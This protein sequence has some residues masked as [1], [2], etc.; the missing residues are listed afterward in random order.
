MN[1]KDELRK[2]VEV[3]EVDSH[4]YQLRLK[5][6]EELP[7]QLAQLTAAFEEKK[8]NLVLYEEKVKQAQLRKKERELDLATKEENVK[9]TQGQLYSLKTN[10]EY[11]AKL[12]EIASLKADVSL[13]EEEVLKVMATI[14]EADKI[15]KAE[16]EK[17]VA[18]E[19]K[20]K[21]EEAKVKAEME[22]FATQLA[23]LDAKRSTLL[24]GVDK[25]ILTR[26][27]RLV[28]TRHG[29]AI[30]NA[31]VDS[32]ICGA[33]HMRVTPQKINDIKMYSDL[34]FCESCLR[35]LYIAEDLSL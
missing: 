1:L 23:Q 3:Q 5:K 32:E 20:F 30:A 8:K 15:F 16:K 19:N 29:L 12:T 35:I 33:C 22:S 7:E 27:E 24:V 28:Q 10:K 25:K 13:L 9:K 21:E 2:I 26:Y 11:Q 6:D 31:N 4:I 17:I 18:E 14:E 34:V